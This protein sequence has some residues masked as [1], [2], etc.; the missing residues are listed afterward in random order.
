M[1]SLGNTNISEKN[2][3]ENQPIYLYTVYDYDG[4]RISGS[5]T[6][7]SVNHLVDTN[8]SFVSGDVGKTIHNTTDNTY[9]VITVVN[10]STNVTLSKNIMASGE[11]YDKENN[12][13]L[14]QYDI[15]VVF[16]TI[17]YVAF[18][19]KF[20]AI[21]ENAQGEIDTLK[22]TLCNIS[23][24]IQSYLE[25]YDWRGKKVK[26]TL[27]WAN[28]LADANVKTEDIFYIDSYNADE[29]NVEVSL[30]SKFDILDLNIPARKYLRNNCG[31]RQLGF[32]GTECGAVSGTTCDG[33]LSTCQSLTNSTRYG[34]FP[35]IPIGRIYVG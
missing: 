28:Q 1:R 19:I 29:L 18:P 3:Q 14:A 32:K 33:R 9:A 31:W 15:N 34:G 7:T 26:M 22:I 13:Y 21:G 8:A 2:K 20:D 25:T 6:S 27:V 16:D 30:S 35:S 12:L 23:R 4:G 5:A 10:S 17:T 24:L 11:A